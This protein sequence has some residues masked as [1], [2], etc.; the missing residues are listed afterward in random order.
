MRVDHGFDFGSE[1]ALSESSSKS[2]CAFPVISNA[3]FVRASS[4]SSRSLRRRSLLQLDLLGRA[5]SASPSAPGRRGRRRRGPCATPRCARCTGPH[6]AAAHPAPP[7]PT[8]NASYSSRIRALYSAVNDRRRGRA[9]GSGSSTTPS[10]ARASRD[11][12]VMVIGLRVPVSPCRDGGLPQVSH[13]SLTDRARCRP[14]NVT[15]ATR[16]RRPNDGSALGRQPPPGAEWRRRADRR[17][18]RLGCKFHTE[19]AGSLSDSR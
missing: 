2:A 5:A 1:S 3:S 10:W 17:V 7:S 4:A 8:G 14:P 11:A 16:G 13:V 15:G 6:G 18:A 12:V 9:A 19:H